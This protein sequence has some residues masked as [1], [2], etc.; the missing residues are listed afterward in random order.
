MTALEMV[1]DG[2]TEATIV[3]Y[4]MVPYHTIVSYG[5]VVTIP[6][7]FLRMDDGCVCPL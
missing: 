7:V 3:W 5:M 1:V 6:S 2:R 4:G